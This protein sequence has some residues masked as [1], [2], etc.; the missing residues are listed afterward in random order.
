MD[1]S[2]VPALIAKICGDEATSF[3][4]RTELLFGQ[5]KSM[6][7]A[8]LVSHIEYGGVIPEAYS[9]DSS[10]EKL[11][12]KYCDY[13]LAKALAEL[14]MK[15]S[16]IEERADS[17]DVIAEVRKYSLVGDAKAFRLSRTAK[18]QK[19]FKVE[20][21][22]QWKKKSDYACLV[23]PLYQCPTKT[24][25]IYDQA[26]RY[27]VTILSFTHLGFLLRAE[28]IQPHEFDKLWTVS[29]T[30]ASGK[31][32]VPYWNAISHQVALAA[33]KSIE[34]WD[35]YLLESKKLL[36]EQAKVQLAFWE[37]EKKRIRRM[38]HDQAV[39][40]LISALRIDSNISMITRTIADLEELIT[41][42]D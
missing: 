34:Q 2:H 7:R 40:E 30:L 11:F 9:H 12:A 28:E 26:I 1:Y 22:N 39:E 18:N 19:D 31:E 41:E 25:Q 6:D 23:C 13:L 10:E 3:K 5:L 36:H 32:A 21:L 16:V 42:I 24:S 14:G 4:E 15:S 27:N 8:A 35:K 29:S 38:D 17:A 33:G 20:A 37:S